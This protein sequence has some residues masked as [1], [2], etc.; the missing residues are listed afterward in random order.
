MTKITVS[1]LVEKEARFLR[2]ACGVRYWED[3]EVNGVP[4][5]EDNPTIPFAALDTWAPTIDIDA[6]TIVDWPAGTT[7]SVHYKVCDDGR[8]TL[9]DAGLNV[10]H[11]IEGYVP[12]IM[13]PGG[14]GYGDYVIMEIDGAG[15]IADWSADDLSEF[16]AAS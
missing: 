10:I 1:Q 3:S 14:D 2:V 9:L 7:A 16:G 12:S 13:C 6:G 4:D 11:E 8:Y 5:E 15:K